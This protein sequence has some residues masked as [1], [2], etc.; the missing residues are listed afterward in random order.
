MDENLQDDVSDISDITYRSKS[1]IKRGCCI[2]KNKILNKLQKKNC[3]K[4]DK[5]RSSASLGG[6]GGAYNHQNSVLN[7]TNHLDF[8]RMGH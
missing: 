2:E 8:S 1:C 7:S 4:A 3:K 5:I 6:G